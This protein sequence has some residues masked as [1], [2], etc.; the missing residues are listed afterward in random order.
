MDFYKTNLDFFL[1]SVG[2]NGFHGY[3]PELDAQPDIQMYLLKGCPGG[4]KS[5]L[6]RRVAQAS[7][8]PYERIHCS[9]DPDSL[10]G[11]IL[12][13][14]YAAVIDA[15]A[16]HALDPAYPGVCQQTVDLY[17][18]MNTAQLRRQRLQIIAA[19][20][21]H[22]GLQERAA[23]YIQTASGLLIDSRRTV[24]PLLDLQKIQVYSN[25]L[26]LRYL[27]RTQKESHEDI[28]LLSAVTPQGHIVFR[29]TIDALAPTKI[30]FHDPFGAAAP[31]LLQALRQHA[32]D[33]GYH[34]ITC[35]CSLRA[36]TI[37]H[38]FVPELGLAFLTSNPWHPME[39]DEQK[40]IHFTRFLANDALKDRKKR[41]RFNQRAAA[42]LL[43]Q[44]SEVQREAKSVHDELEAYYKGSIDFDQVTETGNQ[45]L[46]SIFDC[47]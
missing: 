32:L 42:E 11:V 38:L 47:E 18:T 43:A 1:G 39:F 36:D 28:R 8:T 30:V 22:K 40:N 16:P 46:H 31:I 6:M 24:L 27:P 35:P 14:P 10:D 26:A 19:F 20:R 21:R 29:N 17:H 4:G 23:R 33:R 3:F 15:T 45:L 41:L 12:Q 34:I 13:Q 9:S 7:K 25:R 5:S 44:A 2:Q 37:D